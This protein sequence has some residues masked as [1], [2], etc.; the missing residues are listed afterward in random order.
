MHTYR[1]L[2][3]NAD[4]KN[5]SCALSSEAVKVVSSWIE[6]NTRCAMMK[7]KHQ[8]R[9]WGTQPEF[10]DNWHGHIP[11]IIPASPLVGCESNQL[12]LFLS[13]QNE[14]IPF[15]SLLKGLGSPTSN[16]CHVILMNLNEKCEPFVMPTQVSPY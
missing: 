11:S 15:A 14:T 3:C 9:P 10:K 1:I 12:P 7:P 2:F 13:L 8:F 5:N 6:I 4:L 16:V